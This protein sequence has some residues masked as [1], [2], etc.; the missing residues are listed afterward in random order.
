MLR[1]T[2]ADDGP[3]VAGGNG[4]SVREGIGL[5]NTR[6]RLHHLYGSRATV[7]LGAAHTS[8]ASPGTRVEIRIPGPE[9][10]V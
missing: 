6:A 3:G 2:L 9:T 1:I 8:G 5:S 10:P 4:T 7:E